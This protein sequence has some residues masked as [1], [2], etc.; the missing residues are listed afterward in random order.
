[1][2][3]YAVFTQAAAGAVA[4]V[5]VGAQTNQGHVRLQ[6]AAVHHPAGESLE[7][8]GL[9]LPGRVGFDGVELQVIGYKAD[10]LNKGLY[11]LFEI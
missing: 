2:F 8:L 3:L 6:I 5:N 9:L 10:V 7:Y 1:M 11:H 4:D